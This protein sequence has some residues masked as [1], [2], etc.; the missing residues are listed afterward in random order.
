MNCT[1]KVMT[2]ILSGGT[3]FLCAERAFSRPDVSGA[4]QV[5]LLEPDDEAPAGACGRVVF[6]PFTRGSGADVD[7]GFEISDD[8]SHFRRIAHQFEIFTPGRICQVDVT[9]AWATNAGDRANRFD[10]VLYADERHTPGREIARAQGVTPVNQFGMSTDRQPVFF[11][12][13]VE[14]G[15]YWISV[16]GAGAGHADGRLNFN[17]GGIGELGAI[18]R[19]GGFEPTELK[20]GATWTIHERFDPVLGFVFGECPG[21]MFFAVSQATPNARVA[22]MASRSEGGAIVPRGFP[23]AGIPLDLNRDDLRLVQIIETDENG[24]AVFRGIVPVTS[25][26]YMLQAIDLATCQTSNTT[27]VTP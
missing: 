14:P 24:T 9:F 26:R 11:D 8:P 19:G 13:D 5:V 4:A 23:C 22:L 27:R 1:A 12:V 15:R 16:E 17:A 18:D 10:F 6:D 21:R 3:G 7:S 2:L 25:C 20:N